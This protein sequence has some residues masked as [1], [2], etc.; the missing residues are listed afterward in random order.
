MKNFD[1]TIQNRYNEE[2]ILAIQGPNALVIVNRLDEQVNQLKPMRFTPIDDVILSTTGYTGETGFEIYAPN[3]IILELWDHFIKEG[4]VPVG[5]GARDTLRLD[6]GY[7][8]YGHELSET[9]APTESVA[10][11]TVKWKKEDFLGKA[12][13]EKLESFADKRSQYGVILVD[14]GIAREGYDV[15]QNGQVIGKVTSGTH[16]PSLNQAIAIILVKGKLEE[17]DTVEIQIR[18]NRVQA[19]VVKLPFYKKEEK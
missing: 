17:G 5:L 14:K 6:M 16:S 4:V 3:S 7:A 1:V 18:K 19:Y 9:I 15:I 13:L 2:G 8:L 12:A 11:W 10:S